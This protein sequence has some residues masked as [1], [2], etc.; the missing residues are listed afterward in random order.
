M[1]TNKGKSIIARSL[2]GQVA[3]PFSYIALGT[4]ALPTRPVTVYEKSSSTWTSENPVLDDGVWG[5]ETN[6]N[7]TK[8]GDG[9]TAWTSLPYVAGGIQYESEDFINKTRLDFEAVRVPV[10]GASVIYE[11]GKTKVLLSA[12]IPSFQRYEF[13]EISVFS[14]EFNS[15]LTTEPSRMIYTFSEFEGWKFHSGASVTEVP[16]Y[17]SVSDNSF[18]INAVPD[19][20]Q[21][22]FIAANSGVF[23]SENRKNQ[24]PRIYLDALTVNGSMSSIVI[25]ETPPIDAEWALSGN[26]V[27]V[28]SIPVNLSKARPDDELKFSFAVLNKL[29][30]DIVNES[31][32]SVNPPEE[33]KIVLVFRESETL[34]EYAK[35]Q[36]VLREGEVGVNNQYP[37]ETDFSHNGYY[38][39]AARVD[40]LVT[41]ANFS[42]ER[43]T[44]AQVFVDVEPAAGRTNEDYYVVLDAVRFDSTND[45]NPAY[46]MTAYSVVQNYAASTEV[47][48]NQVESQIEYKVV[49]EVG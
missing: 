8:V 44:L 35:M 3:S 34:E 15:M 17:G 13:S 5:F 7:L 48:E 12:A 40:S 1:I 30:A 28:T 26:H 6:T 2:S 20:S 25:D 33:V 37:Q 47:K 24:R 27:H 36:I 41:T 14:A 43:V 39:A 19:D 23:F 31:N 10:S 45:N 42:W 38:V 18:D 21:A 11:S 29:Y 9:A 32:V 46:G 4:G 22:F 49:L 16:Y